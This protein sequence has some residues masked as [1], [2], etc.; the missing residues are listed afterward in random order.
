MW[1]PNQRLVAMD[2]LRGFALLGILM[3]NIQ[4]FSMPGAAYLNPTSFGD[5]SGVNLWTWLVTHIFFDQKFMTLFSIL[6]GAGVLL[7]CQNAEAKGQSAGK[8]HYTRTFWL[9]IFGLLH[10]Y[11]FWYGD[12]LY[13]YA[14]CGF[15]IYLFRNRSIK[16][17]LITCGILLLISS[18][19]SLGMGAIMEH[20]PDSEKT[21]LLE[22]WNPNDAHEAKEITAYANGFLTGIAHRAE[23]TFFMQTYVFLTMFIWR[24]TAMMLLGMALFK[25]GFFHLKW[26][27][28][29]YLKLI[30]VCLPLG[31]TLVLL[32]VQANLKHEFS[33]EFSMFI[34]SQFNYWASVLV[35]LSYAAGIMLLVNSGSLT[36][37]QNRLAAIGKTAFSNYILHTLVFTTIFYGYGFGLFADIERWQQLL[38]VIAMWTLQ[39]WLAP[40]WLKRFRFGPLE[41]VWRNLTYWQIQPFKKS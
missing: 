15:I 12:I 31:L 8:L 26:Q 22:A 18:L 29:S 4:S 35:A 19:Y 33:L 1:N 11:L 27:S 40:V 23:E 24:G 28:K 25:S 10:G 38:M 32:G 17:L 37:L 41:W 6:F 3:V 34:G 14:M 16:A 20:I 39:L 13:A 36:A 5:F 7:F 21:A 2:V 9:L 30:A